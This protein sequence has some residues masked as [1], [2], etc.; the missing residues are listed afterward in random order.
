MIQRWFIR[1]PG[2]YFLLG[3]VYGGAKS[4]LPLPITS[5]NMSSSAEDQLRILEYHD[6]ALDKSMIC[7]PARPHHKHDFLHKGGAHAR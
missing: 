1:R 5:S 4:Q 3:V 2:D 6:D 7:I